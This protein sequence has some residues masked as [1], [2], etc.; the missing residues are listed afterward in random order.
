MRKIHIEQRQ[1]KLQP[2]EAIL[3]SRKESA[4]YFFNLDMF[5]G[6]ILVSKEKIFIIGK[7]YADVKDVVVI[8]TNNI[9][10]ELGVLIKTY[11]IHKIYLDE[12]YV[13]YGIVQRISQ[14][15]LIIDKYND[16][17]LCKYAEDFECILIN[18]TILKK[19]MHDV[20]NEIRSEDLIRDIHKSFKSA[21][22]K[23]DIQ[24]CFISINPVT[25]ESSKVLYRI[26][27]NTVYMLDCGI[28]YMGLYSDFT[29]T[30]K[31]NEYTCR[32]LEC[33]HV[34]EALQKRISECI[35]IG[36]GT[37]ELF[38]AIQKECILP[39]YYELSYGFGH[40]VGTEVHESFSLYALEDFRFA[41]N[42][43]FTIEPQVRCI[44]NNV[45]QTYRI[46]STYTLHNGTVK[47]AFF[48]FPYINVL[49]KEQ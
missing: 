41:D 46:E 31:I 2:N 43:I 38:S 39:D 18:A 48:E 36:V 32:E 42:M 30:F 11:K 16:D 26:D 35:Q 28:K 21:A 12:F 49:K 44:V 13:P 27:P 1:Q 10:E 15:G 7:Y 9:I 8:C 34:V 25:N 14:Q 3:F 17:Q 47:N 33:V 19:V 24:D 29:C 20:L 22:Y 6:I 4:Q 45:I 40:S 37:K 23:Y 5:N